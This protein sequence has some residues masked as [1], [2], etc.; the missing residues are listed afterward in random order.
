MPRCS[1]A[2]MSMSE[3]DPASRIHRCVDD[4]VSGSDVGSPLLA[5]TL[6]FA[7]RKSGWRSRQHSGG[8]QPRAFW[9]LF[10]SSQSGWLGLPLSHDAASDWTIQVP[11]HVP[12][13]GGHECLSPSITPKPRAHESDLIRHPYSHLVFHISGGLGSLYIKQ[14][15]IASSII[16][17]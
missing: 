4:K 13:T 5:A 14:Q 16:C 9:G 7:T 6:A 11:Q 17:L 2:T 1:S 12:L 3:R 10:L 8:G 15:N